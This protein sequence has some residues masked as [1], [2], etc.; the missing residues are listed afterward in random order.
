MKNFSAFNEAIGTSSLL[1]SV[2]GEKFPF[3]LFQNQKD[4]A[5][6]PVLPYQRFFWTK[7]RNVN[8]ALAEQNLDESK[9]SPPTED[10][11]VGSLV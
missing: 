2:C 1:L 4:S 6:R 3:V 11:Q 10:K 7:F 9:P 5:R 8:G